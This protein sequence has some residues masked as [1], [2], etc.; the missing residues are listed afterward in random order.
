[1]TAA[2]DIANDATVGGPATRRI[3][4][5]PWREPGLEDLLLRHGPEPTA[6]GIVLGIEAEVPF[7]VHYVIRCDE[8]WHVRALLI[9][10][11]GR[12]AASFDL[13]SDGDGTWRDVSG[14]PVANFTGCIDVD[15]SAT[16]FTNTLPIRR[17]R[18][19]AGETRDIRVAYVDV[20]AFEIRPELQRYTCLESG[21]SAR[22]RYQSL[23]KGSAY[24]L[25]VDDDGIV[26]D[27]P[28]VFRR[29]WPR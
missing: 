28:G 15:I 3:L 12:R 26:L 21:P 13:R 7:R 1:V 11:T 18:L 6:D 9:E 16:P 2:R 23:P 17:L 29:I 19:G 24:E 20:P 22:Y 10:G 4:W 27:Y 8:R 14:K 25:A 5:S